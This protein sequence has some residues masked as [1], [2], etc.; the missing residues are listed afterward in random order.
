MKE[1]SIFAY[2]LTFL[3]ILGVLSL[4]MAR[5]G[6]SSSWKFLLALYP[7]VVILFGVAFLRRS[8]LFMAV[9]GLVLV[10]A[11]A[12]LQ[13]ST[14]FE[15]TLRASLHGFL[16]SF[17]VSIS[18]AATMLMIYLMKE[19]GALQ[20]V[21][22]VIKQQ[23]IGDEVRA[24]YIG[25]G[26]GSFLT[27]LGVVTPALFPP[28]LL[29]MG[30]SPLASIAIAVLGYNAT[31]SF[32]L[33]SIPITLPASTF[34]FNPL[35]LAFKI[36]A[37]LPVISTGFAF[38]VLWL[39]GGKK[40]MRKGAV[41]ALISGLVLAFACLATTSLDYFTGVQIVPLTL[42]GVI[43]GLSA[44]LSL[45]LY[46]RLK[47]THAEVVKDADYP[48]NRE[49]WRSF[50]PWIILSVLAGVTSISQ[51][52][53]W[54]LHFPGDAQ[55][56]RVFSNEPI[57]LK[58]LTEPYTW[59]F[60]AILLSLF[61]LK[62]TKSQMKTATSVWLKHFL[63]PFLTYSLYFSISFVM[64]FSA[65][66]IVNGALNTNPPGFNQ[67]NM[68]VILGTTLASVFGA[69]YI[70]VAASLGLFGAIVAGSET[71]SNILFYSIQKTATNSLGLNSDFM[72]IYSSHAVAG[73]VA[74]AVTPAK[75]NNAVVTIDESHEIESQMMRK[76]LIIALAL[77]IATGILTAVLI[78][79]GI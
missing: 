28:L 65:M 6:P 67:L 31:T 42:V 79:L 49:V 14:P 21:S 7:L 20:T 30:F 56:I 61:T 43:A 55:V 62:P 34:G 39:I 75:I 74:S 37:F 4:L 29:A 53:D 50:S 12:F 5:Y 23:V 47:P 32:A 57:N 3:L 40:S 60:I 33:L 69:G 16:S 13:F 59:I 76:N 51:I 45:H 36:S 22:K 54:L 27:S 35:A 48:P 72:T 15:V 9:V 10:I 26:F 66:Q 63:G 25:I 52:S 68:N 19:A 44:M 24:L 11:L 2:S 73:G 70:F 17:G 46:Q 58:I 38:A 78:S 41:P 77:T 64:A 1:K 18:V 8:G 71:S